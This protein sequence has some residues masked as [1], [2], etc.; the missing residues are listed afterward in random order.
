MSTP[1]RASGRDL[2]LPDFPPSAHR[3]AEG[4]LV[5]PS[6]PF[7]QPSCPQVGSIRFGRTA[8]WLDRNRADIRDI[9]GSAR[10]TADYRLLRRVTYCWFGI[11][12]ARC[13][14]PRRTGCEGRWGG[15]QA[16]CA[17]FR[18]AAAAAAGG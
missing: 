6:P 3:P 9:G 16:A 1:V 4:D 11:D 17:G 7:P 14:W 2:R 15:G 12:S 5:W 10:L 8:E 18:W 13:P